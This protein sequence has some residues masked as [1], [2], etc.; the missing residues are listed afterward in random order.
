MDATGYTTLNRQT[1][2]LREMQTVANNIANSA[3]TGY[4]SEGLIFSEHV[5]RIEGGPSLSMATANVRHTSLS[6]GT[7]TQTNAP[8]DIAIQGDGFFLIETAEG[9]RLS[10][11]GSFALSAEG[12][13]VTQDGHR[14][15]DAG[16]API[17][18]PPNSGEVGVSADG[19]I[20]AD[21]QLLGQLGVV[22]PA[23]SQ[24]LVR[25][26]G[27]LFRTD[28]D[29]EPVATPNLRQGFLENSNVDPIIEMTRMIEVQ[30]AYE[31]G[32]SFLDAE[33]ERIRDAV[34]TLMR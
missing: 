1:G 24:S 15:L 12:D 31:M 14:V 23:D 34:K 7:M 27:V 9:E 19:T 30:R 8:L 11:A 28:D 5:S 13:L 17:F 22:A 16:G 18:I 4:R 21:G 6:L 2:L 29:V 32:Q 26:G 3:T 10:R 33:N 25:E 20:S